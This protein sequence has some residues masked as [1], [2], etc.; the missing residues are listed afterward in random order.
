[1]S[2]TQ[3]DPD[4]LPRARRGRGRD[5]RQHRRRRRRATCKLRI[6]EPPRFFEAF[7]RGRAFTEAP[8]ITARICGICPVAYQMSAV[9]RDGGRSAVSQVDGPAARAAA[10]ALLRRMDREPRA[11]RL[12]APRAR[13]PGLRRAPSSWRA[14]TRDDRRARPASSRR[15][16]TQLMTLIG[17][18]EIHPI[19]VRVGGFYRVPTRA[20]LAPLVPS[21][22][23]ARARDRGRDGRA[24]SPGFDFPDFEQDYEFVALATP[25]EYPIDR[26]R[27][28]S[29]SGPRH[30]RLASTTTT[31]SRSMSRTPTRCIRAA[32]A[33]RVPR[34]PLARFALNVD[35]LSPLAREAAREAGLAHRG[36]TRSAASWSARRDALCLRR[37][38]AADRR[39]RS[40][41]PPAVEVSPRAGVGLRLHRG[42][43]RASC[44]TA[45][46]STTRADPS[47]RRSCRPRRRTRARSRTTSRGRRALAGSAGRRADAALRAGGPQLRPLHL[48]RDPLPE[49]RGRAPLSRVVVIGVGNV[50]RG[51]DAVGLAVARRS[52]GGVARERRGA[53]AGGRA[54]RL[55]RDLGGRRGALAGRRGLVRGRAGHGSPGGC[56]PRAICRSDS[57]GVDP[58]LRAQRRRWPWREHLRRLPDRVVVFGI[59]GE[60]FELGD[61]LTPRVSVGRGGG[62][63][64]RIARSNFQLSADRL[65]KTRSRLAAQPHEIGGLT[66]MAYPAGSA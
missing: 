32:R 29:N 47:T 27:I 42:A 46:R 1:M 48:V 66:R 38:V 56:E 31:S 8:D 51:D 43:T 21:S 18:R 58:S 24:W 5:V 39:V 65:R 30:R 25:G 37:G 64:G 16:A 28:V 12:H 22:S 11:A 2:T 14:T 57:A 17:G 10:P 52:A 33:R 6:F 35:R 59:E 54:D 61:E 40:A 45:T 49:A 15:P 23:S 41:R 20:E 55:D 53:R 26:G 13:L 44:T 7:L 34:G 63:Q 36:A 9:Q 4:R 19:N 50:Y 3:D 62:R 60:Q